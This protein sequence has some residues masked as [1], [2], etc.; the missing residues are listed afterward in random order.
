VPYPEAKK[1]LDRMDRLYVAPLKTRTKSMLVVGKPNA[2]KT[3]LKNKFLDKYPAI[4]APDGSR[5]IHGVLHIEAP[6]KADPRAFCMSILDALGAS[7]GD[8]SFAVLT[9]QVLKLLRETEVKMLV[10]DE[11]HNFLTGRRDMKDALMN[12]V[13]SICNVLHISVIAFGVPSA[14]QV[15]VNDAQLSSRFKRVELPAWNADKKLEPLRKMLASLEQALP[16]LKAS[17]LSHKAMARKIAEMS[18]GILGEVVDI[19]EEA[20]IEA[21]E[22]GEEQITIGLLDSLGWMTPTEREEFQA[23]D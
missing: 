9:N 1:I 22:T 13:R 5:T 23:D 15:F 18:D 11:I 7:Y 14:Q 3:S 20:T 4:E 8:V 17:K 12:M 10:V 19:L 16:L 2:G 6:P 21:I